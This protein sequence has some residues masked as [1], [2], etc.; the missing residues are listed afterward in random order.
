MRPRVKYVFLYIYIG[1]LGE[2][3]KYARG[4]G[5]EFF[6]FALR[7]PWTKGSG[8]GISRAVAAAL[9]LRDFSRNAERLVFRRPFLLSQFHNLSPFLFYF[10]ALFLPGKRVFLCIVQFSIFRLLN[11]LFAIRG[12]ALCYIE[13]C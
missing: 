8:G 11:F 5:D 4:R 12:T 9:I 3:R 7:I 1:E 6:P 2:R 13:N 10:I